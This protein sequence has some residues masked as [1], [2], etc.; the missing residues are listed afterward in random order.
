MK[1]LSDQRNYY[2][3]SLGNMKTKIT[4]FKAHL[5]SIGGTR[6]LNL[7]QIP[8][9]DNPGSGYQRKEEKSSSPAKNK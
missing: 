1:E 3:E 2:V 8:N 9:I 4:G 5:D 6:H 7:Q